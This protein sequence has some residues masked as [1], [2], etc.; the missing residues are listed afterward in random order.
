MGGHLA[1]HFLLSSGY[2]RYGSFGLTDDI[3][4]PERNFKYAA[5]RELAG[6]PMEV[7]NPFPTIPPSARWIVKSYAGH[8]IRLEFTGNPADLDGPLVLM[9][10]QG[11]NVQTW[12]IAPIK[13][14]YR[15]PLELT[16]SP[17]RDMTTGMYLLVWKRR[18][19]AAWVW[20]L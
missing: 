9:D 19:V 10:V 15:K 18:K 2:T 13:Q 4:F 17:H 14:A 6:G 16:L 1:M 8:S 7:K 12:Q 3:N 5:L 11:R 20:G